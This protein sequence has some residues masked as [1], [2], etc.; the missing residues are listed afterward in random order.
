MQLEL[1]GVNIWKSISQNKSSGR[2]E[3]LLNMRIQ[4][5]I[6]NAPEPSLFSPSDYGPHKIHSLAEYEDDILD[7]K[8]DNFFVI[9]RRNWKLFAGSYIEQ[10]WTDK[11]NLKNM[12]RREKSGKEGDG[13]KLFDLS[14]DPREKHD[15][16]KQNPEVVEEIM[17]RLASYKEKMTWIGKRHS[18]NAGRKE[19][20]WYP[21][22]ALD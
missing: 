19:G 3:V 12:R 14:S 4:S 10:G 11:N 7:D 5:K 16:S 1:D 21:W 9:R 18:S 17:A 15:V 8:K 2:D 13:I 20:I 6:Y 22:V